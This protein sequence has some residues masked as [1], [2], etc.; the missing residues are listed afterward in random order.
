M[1]ESHQDKLEAVIDEMLLEDA[2]VSYETL[3][4]WCE[5]YPDLRDDLAR[6][7]AILAVQQAMPDG[8]EIDDARVASRLMSRAISIMHGQAADKKEAKGVATLRLLGAVAESGI[9]EGEFSRRCKLDDTLVAKLNRRLIRT[10]SI[11]QAAFDLIAAT[12]AR[13]VG[14]VRHVLAG[15]PVVLRAHKSSS[16]PTARTEDFLD[17]VNSSNLPEEAKREWHRIVENERKSEEG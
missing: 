12:L 16:Q 15:E 2:E 8:P 17:A 11:P 14:F 6:L 7:A 13:E 3:A 4:R 1:T 5:R 10:T 9:D